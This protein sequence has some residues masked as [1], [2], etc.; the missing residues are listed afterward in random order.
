MEPIVRHDPRLRT[1]DRQDRPMTCGRA[2][3]SQYRVVPLCAGDPEVA[4]NGLQPVSRLV[5]RVLD[6]RPLRPITR[7]RAFRFVR[8]TWRRP[9]SAAQAVRVI[10]ALEG[11][12][13]EVWVA[14]GWGVDALVGRT[15]RTHEDLDLMCEDGPDIDART[16]A[17][18]APLGYRR[19]PSEDGGLHLRRRMVSRDRRGRTVDILPVVLDAAGAGADGEPDYRRSSFTRGRI[20]SHDVGCLT[21]EEQ[22]RL[23][24]GYETRRHDDR[25]VRLLCQHFDLVPPP[26]HD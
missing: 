21:V 1:G 14:G 3:P 26:E 9:M 6:S 17:V 12:G 23:H 22:L 24:R 11:A 2:T 15:T 7:T 18:L 10:E 20:G 5:R 19:I 8:R 13:F 16:S 25:D 4:T